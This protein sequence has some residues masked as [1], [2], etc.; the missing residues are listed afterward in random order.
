MG[1][2][3]SYLLFLYC[4]YAESLQQ[5]HTSVSIRSGSVTITWKEQGDKG[6]F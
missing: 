3:A 1:V 2:Y 5:V 4:T 6:I